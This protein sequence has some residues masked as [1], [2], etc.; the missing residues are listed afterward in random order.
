MTVLFDTGSSML[1][2]QAATTR[3]AVN[4]KGA[5]FDAAESTT[6]KTTNVQAPPIEYVDGT[7]VSGVLV[8]D[9]VAI[10][11]LAIRNL[12]FEVATS[13]VS[14]NQN[15]SDMDGIMGLSF[16]KPGFQTWWEE[17]A[18]SNKAT[19]PVFGYHV[20]ESNTAGAFTFGGVDLSR[21]DGDLAWMPLTQSPT[22]PPYLYWQVA[23]PSISLSSSGS[24]ISLGTRFTTIWDTGTSLATLP[25]QVAAQLNRA[26]GL[27]PITTE[28]PFLYATAC[29]GGRIPS[30]FPNL[31]FEFA[32]GRFTEIAPVDYIFLQPTDTPG[33]IA[34]VSGFVGQDLP[35]AGQTGVG[36]GVNPSAIFGNIF[37]RAF[38]TVFDSENKCI[39]V[40]SAIRTN[41]L[42]PNLGV[43]PQEG[44]A[45]GTGLVNSANSACSLSASLPTLFQLSVPT[46]F[47]LFFSI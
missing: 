38:Y 35:G 45:M 25:I 41:D 32:E 17:V 28:P 16:A 7:R 3:G 10:N 22:N 14:S 4:Q 33:L 36:G 26:L 5:L 13:I 18:K 39:G 34:C 2:V 19:S 42:A 37:L 31:Q 20:D 40:A 21:F 43:P 30:S 23:M 24:R 1:W 46:L 11:G 12:Q 9:T 8:Q 15:T 44:N 27:R 29:P 47:L 6:L